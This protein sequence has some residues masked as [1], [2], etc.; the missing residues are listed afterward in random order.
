MLFTIAVKK[1]NLESTLVLFQHIFR[2]H[3]KISAEPELSG[4]LAILFAGSMN[5]LDIAL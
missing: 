4:F 1:F 5:Q 2:V 3:L